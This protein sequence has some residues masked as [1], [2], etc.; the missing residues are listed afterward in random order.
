MA[1]PKAVIKYG[2]QELTLR[3]DLR[4]L[5][6]IERKT[7]MGL[8][9]LN[10]AMV[11]GVENPELFEIGLL[12]DLMVAAIRRTHPDISEDEIAET[13]IGEPGFAA[14][15]AI[16]GAWTELMRQLFPQQASAAADPTPPAIASGPGRSSISASGQEMPT[17]SASMTSSAS[18]TDTSS[19]GEPSATPPTTAPA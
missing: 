19:S 13:M 14:M 4:T 12:Y 8:D 18:T 2:D 5:R 1:A 3:M 16:G 15:R 11:A 7:G 10:A 6:D 17:P 9:K